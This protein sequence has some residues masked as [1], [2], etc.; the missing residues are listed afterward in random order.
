MRWLKSLML[1]VMMSVV[2][3]VVGQTDDSIIDNID[4]NDTTLIDSDT[5][6]IAIAK[7]ID[8]SYDKSMPAK[9]AMYDMIL[10]ADNVLSRAC[11]NYDMYSFVYQYLI[12][13][14]VGMKANMVVDYM[15][16]LPY[17]EFVKPDEVQTMAMHDIA[18]SYKRVRIGAKAP[19]INGVTIDGVDFNLYDIKSEYSLLFFW[20]YTCPHCRAMIKELSKLAKKDNRMTII[21]ISVS[22][23]K[24]KTAKHLRKS[25][26]NG[27]HIC[28]GSGWNS[29]IVD[30]YAVDM[31]PALILLDEEKNIIEKPFDVDELKRILEI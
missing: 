18:E 13:G 5:L 24:K 14:F 29:P 17:F 16:S 27:Y 21:T 15:T 8:S 9:D 6:R 19:Q 12:V 11:T 31:T 26:L 10:A 4:F 25:H 30:D 22:K 23:D 20:S 3:I 28:D 2:P 7:Y 1:V